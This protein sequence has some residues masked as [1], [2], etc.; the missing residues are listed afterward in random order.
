MINE[1]NL[2]IHEN[3]FSVHTKLIVVNLT[4]IDDT[5]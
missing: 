3:R 5:C 2:K 4:V 1:N